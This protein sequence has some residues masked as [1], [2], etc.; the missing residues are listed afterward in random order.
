M[1]DLVG[2]G[3]WPLTYRV[4]DN[5][6]NIRRRKDSVKPRDDDDVSMTPFLPS[7]VQRSTS[8]MEI[9][10]TCTSLNVTNI[11][12]VNTEACLNHPVSRELTHHDVVAVFVAVVFRAF[13]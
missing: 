8:L 11:T 12:N 5:S 2:L 1:V 7:R 4:K 3:C 13:R 6:C 10:K 9:E